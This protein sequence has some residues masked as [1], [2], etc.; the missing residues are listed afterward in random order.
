M[1]LKEFK[2]ID[3]TKLPL[4][5]LI[6]IIAKNQTLY[7]NHHLEEFD[8][9]ASQLHFLFEI[10]HQNEINQ[11]NLSSR[12]NVDKGAVARSIKKLEDKGLVKRQ[13]DDNNRRQNI[14]SL[15]SKGKKTLEK[16]IKKLNDWE[17]Y[18][19]ND[20]LIEKETLQK[21]LKEIAIKSIEVNKKDE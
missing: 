5:K 14:I 6:S 1:S 3:A 18:I 16:A 17:D 12:C 9:N 2:T 8:I 11:E 19:F 7:L 15:T 13:I 4:G 10:S 21:V 20:N